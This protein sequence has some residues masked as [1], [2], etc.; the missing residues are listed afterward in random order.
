MEGVGPK[1][2][3]QHLQ[4]QLSNDSLQAQPENANHEQEVENFSPLCEFSGSC[5][6]NPSPDGVHFRKIVSHLFGR[7][8]TSTKLI[9][10][11]V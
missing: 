5:H 10:G 11:L 3:E 4:R 1:I 7:N 2:H 9:P 8:K 6:M